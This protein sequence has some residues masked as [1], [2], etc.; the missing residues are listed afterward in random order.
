M[1]GN[2]KRRQSKKVTFSLRLDSE[3]CRRV[4]VFCVMRELCISDF[5]SQATHEAICKIE[6]AE[7]E[8]KKAGITLPGVKSE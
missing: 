4:K 3:F 8:A 2:A 5:I 6:N 1:S 7:V